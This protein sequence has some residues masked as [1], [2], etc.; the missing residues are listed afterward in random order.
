M[1]VKRSRASILFSFV[2]HAT[3]ILLILKGNNYQY[4]TSN[5][6]LIQQMLFVF[7]SHTF[8]MLG[9]LACLFYVYLIKGELFFLVSIVIVVAFILMLNLTFPQIALLFLWYENYWLNSLLVGMILF[10]IAKLLKKKLKF[11]L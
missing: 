2:Y 11:Y 3:I 4:Q 9:V 6:A 5:L 8:L 7:I 10:V 1:Q